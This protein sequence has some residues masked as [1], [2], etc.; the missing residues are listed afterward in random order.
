MGLAMLALLLSLFAPD[1]AKLGADEYATREAESQ[2]CDNAISVLLLPDLTSSP[3]ANDRIARLK[4][5]HRPLSQVQIEVRTLDND[6]PRW[7]EQYLLLNRSGIAHR[8]D[9]FETEILNRPD[10]YVPLFAMLPRPR[11]QTWNFWQGMLVPRDFPAYRDY[12]DYHQGI[13]PD[14]REVTPAPKP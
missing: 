10:H 12:L 5:K 9:F 13:A 8:F 2:R 1:V 3:E 14:P 11:G 6:F 7:V 4:R